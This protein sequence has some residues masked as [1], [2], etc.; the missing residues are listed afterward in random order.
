M[1]STEITYWLQDSTEWRPN[2]FSYIFLAL[3][4]N[5][6]NKTKSAGSSEN[7]SFF[8]LTSRRM[9]VSWSFSFNFWILVKSRFTS[10]MDETGELYLNFFPCSMHWWISLFLACS[11]ARMSASA[12]FKH[13]LDLITSFWALD[14]SPSILS[15]SSLLAFSSLSFSIFSAPW[16]NA[17][18]CNI[19]QRRERRERREND[20]T[21]GVSQA[22]EKDWMSHSDVY[23]SRFSIPLES[24]WK[25]NVARLL[26]KAPAPLFRASSNTPPGPVSLESPCPHGRT[27]IPP[28]VL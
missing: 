27:E 25:W 5:C 2:R 28:S 13:S 7:I 3:I 24:P 8:S 16:Q 9:I 19:R 15:S 22:Q 12:S 1:S 11:L 21:H 6:L 4:L 14:H 26:L 23:N 18:L 10:S 20:M 17:I